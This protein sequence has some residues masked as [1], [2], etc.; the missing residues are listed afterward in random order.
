MTVIVS[1][2]SVFS[3]RLGSII[4]GVLCLVSDPTD[5]TAYL[6]CFSTAVSRFYP[7]RVETS[8]VHPGCLLRWSRDRIYQFREILQDSD[9]LHNCNGVCYVLPM[10][11]RQ[12]FHR[13]AA[14]L[15]I[16]FEEPCSFSI[17][18]SDII[19]IKRNKRKRACHSKR[20][21]RIFWMV[22]PYDCLCLCLSEITD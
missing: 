12:N 17:L 13:T 20:P 9:E 2:C 10:L 16:S 15:L 4:V 18:I 21:K 3:I 1:F 19:S 14:K 22:R 5:T 8:L 11:F 6:P 7:G